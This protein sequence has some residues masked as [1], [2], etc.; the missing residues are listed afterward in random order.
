MYHVTRCPFETERFH[1]VCCDEGGTGPLYD[2]IRASGQRC[3]LKVLSSHETIEHGPLNDWPARV[4]MSTIYRI[5][6]S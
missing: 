4:K 2:F 3:A 6:L 5:F 1:Q